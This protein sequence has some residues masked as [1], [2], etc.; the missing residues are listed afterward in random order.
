MTPKPKPFDFQEIVDLLN[1]S[2][3]VSIDETPFL[4]RDGRWALHRGRYKVHTAR[5][6]FEVLYLGPDVTNDAIDEAHRHFKPGYTHVVYAGSLDTRRRRYHQ[7]RFGSPS[8]KFWSARAYL[9]S[10]I[11]EE[12][13]G[14]LGKLRGLA[15]DLYIDPQVI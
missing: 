8:E 1:N 7:E 2:R 3:S 11:R 12:V 13:E 5:V 9:Q 10:F 4:K 6:D 14:Y 15:P